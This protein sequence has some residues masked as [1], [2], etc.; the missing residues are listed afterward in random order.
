M[1]LCQIIYNKVIDTA[2]LY[3]HSRGENYKNSLRFLSQRFLHTDIQ[4]QG[5]DS[6]QD[7]VTAM[8]LAKLKVENGPGFGITEPDSES[9]F[10]SVSVSSNTRSCLVDNSWVCKQHTYSTVDCIPT[11]S[12]EEVCRCQVLCL[13]S[14]GVDFLI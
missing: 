7:A 2:L 9:I 13:A 5:H 14:I 11:G 4:G 1:F 12:D 6:V 8:K 3:P 10:R